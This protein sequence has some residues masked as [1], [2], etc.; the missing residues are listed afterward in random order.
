MTLSGMS[1]ARKFASA[2]HTVIV[3]TTR[4]RCSEMNIQLRLDS[5]V[6]ASNGTSTSESPMTRVQ[7]FNRVHVDQSS[8]QETS[9][10][11]QEFLVKSVGDRMQKHQQLIQQVLKTEF[12]SDRQA[13]SFKAAPN[14]P[15]FVAL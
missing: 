1:V 9:R 14:H 12:G 3:L 10:E 15:Q 2:D 6:I 5:W 7:S 13:T 4:S 8:G 11:V